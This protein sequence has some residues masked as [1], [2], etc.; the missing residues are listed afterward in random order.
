VKFKTAIILFA[1]VEAL[2]I[3]SILLGRLLL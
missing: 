3:F 1:L 2:I